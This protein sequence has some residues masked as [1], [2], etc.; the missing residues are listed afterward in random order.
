MGGRG[1]SS[2]TLDIVLRAIRFDECHMKPEIQPSSPC[3]PNQRITMQA[4]TQN[5]TPDPISIR[6]TPESISIEIAKPFRDL[7]GSSEALTALLRQ[8]LR[9]YLEE[10]ITASDPDMRAVDDLAESSKASWW[11]RNGDDFLR[12]VDRE[13]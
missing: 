4:T 7:V 11:E 5:L 2:N 12:N 9:L 3:T 10:R 13:T 1:G 6:E 8:F